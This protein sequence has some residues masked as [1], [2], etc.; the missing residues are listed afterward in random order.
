MHLFTSSGSSGPGQPG[1]LA[2]HQPD[3]RIRYAARCLHRR[4]ENGLL[5]VVERHR[6]EIRRKSIL[7][8][9]AEPGRL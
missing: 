1:S 6:D 2:G 5:A 9:P 4:N 7:P 3:S 8:R